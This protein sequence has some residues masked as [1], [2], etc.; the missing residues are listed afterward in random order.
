VM[1]ASLRSKATQSTPTAT[2]YS[3]GNL[4][5]WWPTL[6]LSVFSRTSSGK[7]QGINNTWKVVQYFCLGSLVCNNPSCQ[8]AAPPPPPQ[9]EKVVNRSL[10]MGK[11][12]LLFLRMCLSLFW[13]PL[14]FV[15]AVSFFFWRV[16]KHGL[17]N[18]ILHTVLRNFAT[19][20]LQ[21]IDG[22]QNPL[23]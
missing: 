22:L 9:L 4:G 3:F 13:F 20:G 14:I 17:S 19:H 5:K 21:L 11:P 18:S 15:E 8:W 10:K 2:Q 16:A 12:H 1:D 23:K 7:K 6:A